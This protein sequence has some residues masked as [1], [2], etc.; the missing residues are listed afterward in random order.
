[1]NKDKIIEAISFIEKQA[2]EEG[3]KIAVVIIGAEAQEDGTDMVVGQDMVCMSNINEKSI[4]LVLRSFLK[5]REEDQT[6][7]SRI[8]R[9]G[10]GV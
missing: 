10:G 1:M 7:V 6:T 5:L 3:K 8:P 2:R 4:D 9:G